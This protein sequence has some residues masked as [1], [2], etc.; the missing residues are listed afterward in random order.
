MPNTI[1]LH[2]VHGRRD[3]VNRMPAN[4]S[5]YVVG[6]SRGKAASLEL[7]FSIATRVHNLE[8]HHSR[9][10]VLQG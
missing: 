6:S 3:M 9:C 7:A 8:M 2:E 10:K 4:K 5:W 1:V